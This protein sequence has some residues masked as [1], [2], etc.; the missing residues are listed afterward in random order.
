LIK[1]VLYIFIRKLNEVRK[2]LNELR[3][4]VHYYE[5]TSDMMTDAVNENTKDEDTEESEYDSEHENSEP[6]TNIR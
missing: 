3:E 2:R 6:I 5:Q 1:W 4:L